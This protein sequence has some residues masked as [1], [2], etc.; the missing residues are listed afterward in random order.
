MFWYCTDEWDP[1]GGGR[2]NFIQD[3][4]Q[5]RDGKQNRDLEAEL[6]SPV[7]WDHEG[8]QVQTQEEEDGQQE[9]DDVEQR[10]PPHGDLGIRIKYMILLKIWKAALFRFNK[11]KMKQTNNFKVYI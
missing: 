10:P 7:V 2:Q 3:E 1:V 6:F 4:L 11:Y 8:G 9:V 5:H